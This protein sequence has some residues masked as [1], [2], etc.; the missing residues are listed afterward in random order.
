MEQ[1]ITLPVKYKD[2]DGNMVEQ[3]ITTTLIDNNRDDEKFISSMT[4]VPDFL[5]DKGVFLD[6]TKLL[7]ILVTDADDETLKEINEAYCDTLYK[8]SGY[9][10]LSYG[11]K[12]TLLQEKGFGYVLDLLLHMYDEDYINLVKEYEVEMK[13]YEQGK[14]ETKPTIQSY[15]DFVKEKADASL[16]RVTA[17]FNLINALKGKTLGLELVLSLID[18]PDYFYLPYNIVAIPQGEWEGKV[19]DLPLPT[20]NPN[21]KAGWGYT[22]TVGNTTNY[23][24]FNGVSWHQCNAFENYT[25]P[26]EPITAIL[27]VYGASSTT[28]QKHL[29]TFVHSYMLPLISVTLKFTD[30]MPNVYA[31]PSGVYKLF[32]MMVMEDYYIDG[33]EEEGSY[34]EYFLNIENI[35]LAKT[36]SEM[37]EILIE[38]FYKKTKEAEEHEGMIGKHIQ[39]NLIHKLSDEHWYYSDAF[40]RQQ[41]CFG[42]PALNEE[43]FDGTIDLNKS[44]VIDKDGVYHYL[45][46]T[47][48][49]LTSLVSGTA[50]DKIDDEGYITNYNGDYLQAPLDDYIEVDFVTGEQKN[51][52][53]I[54]GEFVR[55]T[56]IKHYQ[57]LT[58]DGI[59]LAKTVDQMQELFVEDFEKEFN[60]IEVYLGKE[61]S[62]NCESGKDH[63][64]DISNILAERKALYNDDL[65]SAGVPQRVIDRYVT[66]YAI[67][68]GNYSYY[69]KSMAQDIVNNL[70]NN[71]PDLII[72]S[73]IP[74]FYEF[75]YTKP[76]LREQTGIENIHLDFCEATLDDCYTGIGDLGILG[77]NDYFIYNGMLLYHDGRIRQVGEDKTWTDVG[78]SHAVSNT[79]Y[80]PAIN[81]GKLYY[82]HNGEIDT[83][84]RNK[85]NLDAY[86]SRV[87]KY[88]RVRVEPL[89]N[90]STDELSQTVI[91]TFVED[92]AELDEYWNEVELGTNDTKAKWTHI[93]GYINDYYTAFGICDGR[94]YKL[95]KN[96]LYGQGTEDGAEEPLIIY[97][98]MD[99]D[100]T[101]AYITGAAYSETYEAYGIKDRK[102]YK[103]NQNGFTEIQSHDG[104]RI[105]GKENVQ[106]I[107]IEELLKDTFTYP[108]LSTQDVIELNYADEPVTVTEDE[109]TYEINKRIIQSIKYNG[110]E[111]A[112]TVEDGIYTTD[113]L[114]IVFNDFLDT[115]QV[116]TTP[117]TATIGFIDDEIS[118]FVLEENVEL[119]GWDSSF[120][121]IS[122][123][124]HCNSA[125]TTYGICDGVLYSITN[126]TVKKLDDTKTW[127]AICGFYNDNSPRTFAYAIANG[128]L[129]ELKGD[130]FNVVS[131]SDS[132]YWSEIHGC[133]TATNNF[134][135]GI[136]KE[137]STDTTGYIYKIN[138]KTLSKLDTDNTW[139]TCFGRY[140]TSASVSIIV[141]VM[142]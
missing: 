61:T 108:N 1:L 11:A 101:W 42:A 8:W 109:E 21:V 6:A 123:Y 133:T 130:T 132:L 142:V 88:E 96:P 13:K 62:V 72:L 97:E 3:T 93:T 59:H 126:E 66:N 77:V 106:R 105:T 134:I 79:Y 24:I 23:F 37:Q 71:Y 121:C 138:A 116:V 92:W 64:A 12:I 30:A 124:H 18:M 131:G 69:Q 113:N 25:T 10:K 99:D 120:D 98:I 46:G 56:F 44:Y 4:Y 82:V 35:H 127:T 125:Y 117:Y 2:A 107:F 103:I 58:I 52:E 91:R 94:L 65:L 9:T 19:E 40:N 115:I 32:N 50:I 17:L 104:Q 74:I 60:D 100:Q 140:T 118:S 34:D 47:D 26:R 53:W 112:F 86:V 33:T 110:T 90:E 48:P 76:A 70:Q 119:I 81:D 57:T 114:T 22:K 141:M 73:D 16:T 67:I 43:A 80:T 31:F 87:E 139:V 51:P 136:G 49:T 39:R 20:D 14:I 75:T 78:A 5:Q 54:D 122:R 41:L 128:Q 135:L 15:E 63:I 36:V 85:H 102:L 129:Y 27:D 29:N 38:D 89:N 45:Y 55:D 83:V 111:Q 137:Q 95:F 28:L 68:R 7:D 84:Y